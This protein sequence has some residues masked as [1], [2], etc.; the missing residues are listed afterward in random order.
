M[1]LSCA[2]HRDRWNRTVSDA[3]GSATLLMASLY[4]VIQGTYEVI[5]ASHINIFKSADKVHMNLDR[6]AKWEAS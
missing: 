4:V 2:R 5:C 1:Y 3:E 6:E